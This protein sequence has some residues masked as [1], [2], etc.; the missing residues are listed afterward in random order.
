MSQIT[1]TILGSSGT[2]PI[3]TLTGNEGGPVSPSGGGNINVIGG[4][5]SFINIVG[6]PGTNTL[7]VSL[8]NQQLGVAVTTD[9]VSTSVLFD[10]PIIISAGTALVA[11][12][13]F[14]GATDTYN[15]SVSGIASV[16]VRRP[17]VGAVELN[18]PNISYT[19]TLLAGFVPTVSF[20]LS[21]NNLE[22]R[23]RGENG[24]TINWTV[25]LTFLLA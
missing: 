2:G 1:S 22:F 15:A 8:A 13:T 9:N 4:V 14:V 17:L 23:V 3:L 18:R 10:D 7:T 19:R 25:L 20:A 11:T 12:A 6:S 21:G 16:S 5:D 24:L